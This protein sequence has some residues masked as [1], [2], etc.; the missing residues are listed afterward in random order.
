[1]PAPPLYENAFPEGITKE[2]FELYDIIIVIG[3]GGYHGKEL[4]NYISAAGFRE[5]SGNVMTGV[6]RKI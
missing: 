6:F 4:L 2:M 1:L 3:K 5:V